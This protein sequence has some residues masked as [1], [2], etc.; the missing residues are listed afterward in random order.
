MCIR[1]LC[2]CSPVADLYFHAR[3]WLK[4]QK[5]I[6]TDTHTLPLC[7]F[8]QNLPKF[9]SQKW[10]I[11]H[12]YSIRNGE[13]RESIYLLKSDKKAFLRHFSCTGRS[14]TC[15]LFLLKLHKILSSSH[16]LLRFSSRHYTQ[17]HIRTLFG[18]S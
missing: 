15:Q 14:H 6:R 2:L 7:T 17:T 12:F 16:F 1:H 11:V 8:L 5:V 13:S 18:L 3:L 9:P 4:S 10:Q